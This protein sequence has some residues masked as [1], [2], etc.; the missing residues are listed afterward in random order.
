MQTFL[1]ILVIT[2]VLIG[3]AFS[4]IG[5]LGYFRLPDVYTKLHASGKVG[6]FGVVLL[7]VATIIASLDNFSAGRGLI[8]ILL[9][10]I[11]GP[12]TSHAISSAAYR[13]GIRME[14]SVRDD[15]AQ[16]TR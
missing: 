1:Q 8:L 12:V 14:K 13:L 9:L 4:I 16:K 10:L 11:T 3:T 6:V 2:A 7:L 5:V 15:L